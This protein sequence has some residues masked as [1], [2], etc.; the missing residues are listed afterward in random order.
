[1]GNVIVDERIHR[2]HPEIL[3][4]D[5]LSAWKNAISVVL[6]ATNEKDFLVMVGADSKGRL[7]ELV[8]TEENDGSLR[9]FHAMTPPSTKTLKEVGILR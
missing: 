9:V 3:D 7:L 6:R 1:M 5:V 2:R 8:A 4:T